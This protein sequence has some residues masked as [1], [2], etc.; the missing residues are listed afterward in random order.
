MFVRFTRLVGRQLGAF[1]G[2]CP[3][4]PPAC[5]MAV[6]DVRWPWMLRAYAL[7]C[8][9]TASHIFSKPEHCR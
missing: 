1:I 8:L 7:L 9:R 5:E 3:S 6:D 4:S 2:P